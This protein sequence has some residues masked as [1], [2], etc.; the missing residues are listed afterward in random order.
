MIRKYMV[1]RSHTGKR[2]LTDGQMK[3]IEHEVVLHRGKLIWGFENRTCTE[4]HVVNAEKTH[5]CVDLNDGR[6]LAMEADQNVN[7]ADAVRGSL[8]MSMMLMLGEG[9]NARMEILVMTFES[10]RCSYPIQGIPGTVLVVYYITD[11][12]EWMDSQFF[13]HCDGKM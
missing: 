2:I 8:G 1:S 12:K 5:F 9:A 4:E 7:L 3:F 6:T 10:D 11:P 13:S